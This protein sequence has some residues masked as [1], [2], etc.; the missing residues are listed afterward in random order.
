MDPF[1][2]MPSYWGDFGPK[3]LTSV[4]NHLLSLLL[5]SYDVRIE[6]Y[7]IVMHEDV[8]LHRVRPDL[9]V[10]ATSSWAPGD[11]GTVSVAEP[12]TADLDYPDIEPHTQRRLKI[13]HRPDERVVTILELLSPANK[14]PGAD[15]IEA[16]LEKRAELLASGVN[17]VEVDLLRGGERLPMRGPLPPGDYY[18]Y[19]GTVGRR[20]KCQVFGWPLRRPLPKIPIPL[21]P[22]DGAVVLD[23]AA[24]FRAAYEPALYDRRLPYDQPLAPPPAAADRDWI[25]AALAEKK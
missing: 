11:V 5:P 12:T 18:V 23:L 17:L 20:P 19:V 2:E 1:L 10:T 13:I 16:Y 14:A 15:G 6:E 25:L 21:L 3:L 8:R 7:V 4:S 9:T 22:D 24:A